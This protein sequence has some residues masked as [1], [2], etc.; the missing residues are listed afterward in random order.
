MTDRLLEE[1]VR[2]FV[3]L[4]SA[5]QSKRVIPGNSKGPRPRQV[6]A[7]LL[8]IDDTRHAYPIVRETEAGPQ[9][10]TH[11]RATYS[12]Q[13]YRSGAADT[14][15]RFVA[16]VE[17]ELGLDAARGRHFQVVFPLTRQR[18]DDLSLDSEPEERVL[19]DL[20]VD[21]YLLVDQAIQ[22]IA[23]TRGEFVVDLA[24][25]DDGTGT[26]VTEEIHGP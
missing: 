18:L 7:S 19:V 25:G 8:L 2:S 15:K 11:Y 1:N 17:T 22:P 23:E 14:A 16:W 5:I 13:F 9:T 4:G 10:V 3:A 24:V 26:T 20:P 12:L 6:Y 21:Y